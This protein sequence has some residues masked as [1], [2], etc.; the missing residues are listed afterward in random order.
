MCGVL[1]SSCG[2]GPTAPNP[3]D[4]QN[5]DW[6]LDSLQRADYSIVSPP[7]GASF[8]VRFDDD[9]SLSARADCN[10][11]HALYTVTG[12]ELALSPMACT[13]VACPSAPF[14]SEFTSV[15]STATRVETDGDALTLRSP[16]G[17]LRFVR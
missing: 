7:A 15:L 6:R 9:G 16:Q 3:A 14:D 2:D 13:L 1:L 4:Y 5:V 8:S 17:T 12:T 11:C 10:S